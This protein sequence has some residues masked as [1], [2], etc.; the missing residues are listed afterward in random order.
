MAVLCGGCAVPRAI[1]MDYVMRQAAPVP[2]GG[3]RKEIQVSP[4]FAEPRA[5]TVI[6]TAM[7]PEE[8][9]AWYT[10]ALKAKGYEPHGEYAGAKLSFEKKVEWG[11]ETWDPSIERINLTLWINERPGGGTKVEGDIYC[12]ANYWWDPVTTL[13]YIPLYQV[14]GEADWTVVFR[15]MLLPF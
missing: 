9:K 5:S 10:E 1:G 6:Y 4:W 8:T 14:F 11:R 12:W 13:V 7:T 3:V 15:L 2:E